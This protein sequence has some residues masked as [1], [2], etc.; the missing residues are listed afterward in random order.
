MGLKDVIIINLYLNS[1]KLYFDSN[2]L[3]YFLVFLRTFS[4]SRIFFRDDDMLHVF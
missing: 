3:H 2:Y 4:H 1:L